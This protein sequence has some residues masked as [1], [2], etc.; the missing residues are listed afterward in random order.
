MKKLTAA[1]LISLAAHAAAAQQS[2]WGG[3]E[4]I[5]PEIN[6]DKS[7]TF[8]L[9]APDARRVEITG[10]W[11]LSPLMMTQGNDGIWTLR[12]EPFS[13]EL[14]TYR[15]RIDGVEVND[16]SNTHRQR[17]I[18]SVS[19]YFIIDG[20][21]GSYYKN[22]PI[23]H[24]SVTRLWYPSKSAGYDR[25]ISIYTPPGYENSGDR[26]YPVLYLLHG[27]GGDEESWL[28]LGRAAQILD[29]MIDSG[30]T[31]PMIVVM[32]NGDSDVDSAPGEGTLRERPTF[33]QP[34]LNSG[35]FE[36]NFPE[37]VEYIDSNYRT[38]ADKGHRAI[39]GLSRGG[40]HSRIISAC[41]PDMF[42]YIGL[43][44]PA[45]MPPTLP[46]GIDFYDD[47]HNNLDKITLRQF[48][49]A[50]KLYY[51][52]IGRDDFLYDGNRKFRDNLDSLGIK[53]IYNESDGGHQWRNW[54]LYLM[55]FL[56][57]LFR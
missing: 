11:A 31:E 7:V 25:R 50:P 43:F 14:W 56:P 39:A 30:L 23:P 6:D 17:D 28:S 26:R 19:D 54:R 3:N 32:P 33:D 55:D 29:N 10:D 16:P 20:T 44:S 9:K 42:G 53:Y 15:F 8:R 46:S 52:A 22:N 21:P 47:Y 24:G 45:F 5:S 38:L 36:K 4:L 57:R 41:Y 40:Y 27:T 49:D 1:V 48:A 37:L 13:S 2:L 12:T 51:L 35:E 18:G 34:G